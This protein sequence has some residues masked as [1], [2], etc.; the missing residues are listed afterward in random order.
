M[1]RRVEIEKILKKR[2][3]EREIKKEKETERQ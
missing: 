1:G 2:K 3:R